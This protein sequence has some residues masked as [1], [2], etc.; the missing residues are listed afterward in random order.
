[1]PNY[2]LSEKWANGA[3][4]KKPF[5]Y[6]MGVGPVASDE[7]ADAYEAQGKQ[8][9]LIRRLDMGDLLKLGIAEELDFMSKELLTSE[10]KAD[11]PAEAL[12]NAIMKADNFSQMDRMINLVVSEGMQAPK[13][14]MPPTAKEQK[15]QPGL[16]YADSISFQD[17]MELFTHIFDSEGLSTFRT[18]Q[19][20]SVG[21]VEHE[22][23]VQLPTERTMAEL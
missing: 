11:K 12:G 7:E 6:V 4:Y 16:V 22:Q 2:A 23:S 20:A 19:E 8:V 3:D 14:H 5:N 1:M 13:L 15:R 9:C 21:N 18:E 17:R 10:D